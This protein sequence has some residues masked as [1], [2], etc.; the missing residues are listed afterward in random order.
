MSRNPQHQDATSEF[1]QL[2][3]CDASPRVPAKAPLP[4][5]TRITRC[6]PIPHKILASDTSVEGSEP[7]SPENVG[8]CPN[9][10]YPHYCSLGIFEGTA[11]DPCSC[12]E[13][14]CSL[15]EHRALV[16]HIFEIGLQ[17][18][19]PNVIIENMKEGRS[20][21]FEKGI[22]KEKIKSH[23]QKFR[24]CKKRSQTEFLNE[25][26]SFM[27]SFQEAR[28]DDRKRNHE[29]AF[30]S[31]DALSKLT[32]Q[33]AIGA[34]GMAASLSL[35]CMLDDHF[36]ARTASTTETDLVIDVD[37]Y[38]NN[39]SALLDLNGAL[40]VPTLTPEEEATPLGKMMSNIMGCFSTLQNR[41]I[42]QRQRYT[43]EEHDGYH[44]DSSCSE[45]FDV[46]PVLLSPSCD[47]PWS[48]FK[49]PE[50]DHH[51]MLTMP[52]MI[53]SPPDTPLVVSP[54]KRNDQSHVPPIQLPPSAVGQEDSYPTQKK[55]QKSQRQLNLQTLCWRPPLRMHRGIKDGFV[56]NHGHAPTH[57]NNNSGTYSE[58]PEQLEFG[59]NKR[60]RL[61]G[62]GNGAH[63]PIPCMPGVVGP[64]CCP[65]YQKLPHYPYPTSIPVWQL[66]QQL[67]SMAAGQRFRSPMWSGPPPY[68]PL[69]TPRPPWIPLRVKQLPEHHAIQPNTRNPPSNNIGKEG[70]GASP[71]VN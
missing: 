67:H 38:S 29:Q 48:P 69:P 62:H 53:Q 55:Q 41:L 20:S 49:D 37:D 52:M 13:D 23:L 5:R 22:T 9:N 51:P 54:T 70:L 30:Q 68:G 59:M 42:E 71:N 12:S 64:H 27:K 7:S 40:T 26:D 44:S 25:F 28:D 21:L 15:K 60:I 10:N 43:L 6:T 63:Q 65:P 35:S 46:D 8:T 39:V 18:A 17:K 34:G 24:V 36:G 61:M 33:A 56:S 66:R 2:P 45:I 16:T 3:A 57:R 14:G 19:S 31:S 1:E 11:V 32:D 4:L 58:A 47:R 50:V